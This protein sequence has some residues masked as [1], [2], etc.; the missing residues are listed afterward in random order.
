MDSLYPRC[1]FAACAFLHSAVWAGSGTV[2]NIPFSREDAAE[3][4]DIATGTGTGDYRSAVERGTGTASNRRRHTMR[5][6]QHEHDGRRDD[7][8][9]ESPHDNPRRRR[10]HQNEREDDDPN[11][12]DGSSR[13]YDRR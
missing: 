10:E 8:E 6:T 4:S 11:R 1:L 7:D 9:Q 5:T 13:E 2:R 3:I 12:D